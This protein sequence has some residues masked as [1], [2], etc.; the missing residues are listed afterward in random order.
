[1]AA[2]P[3]KPRT[4]EF[5]RSGSPIV[6]VKRGERVALYDEP[7]GE[8]LEQVRDETEFGS[9]TVFSVSRER[10]GWAA[11][12][13]AHFEN[14]RLV[15]IR[16]DPKRLRAGSLHTEIEIDLSEYRA[17]LLYKDREISTFSVSIGTPTAPTPTGSFAVTDTFRGGLNPAYGCCAVALTARQIRLPSGWLG[18]DRIAIHG[19]SGPLGAAISHGCV[20]AADEDVDYLVETVPPGTPVSIE[21]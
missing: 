8:L 4:L 18:G 6:T 3:P 21:G 17:T 13:T 19:T 15:W 11:V 20:R 10:D 16:L 7:G 12:P 5:P 2:P 1:M 9:P 14:G